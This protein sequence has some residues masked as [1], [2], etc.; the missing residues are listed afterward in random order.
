[1]AT[2]SKGKEKDYVAIARKQITKPS[3]RKRRPKFLVYSR[4]KKGKT[5][6]C[7]SAPN[8]LVIDPEFGTD[9]NRQ[10]DPHVWHVGSWAMMQ[11]VLG[12]AKT[13]E[14]CPKPECQKNPHS[15]DWYAVDGMTKIH[16]LALHHVMKME[17]ERSLERIPGFV[18][19]KDYGKANELVR[20]MMWQFHALP[21]GV[22]YT[23][24][25]RMLVEGE[26][27][28]ED[29]E[30]ENPDVQ[31][32]PDLPKGIRSEGNAIVDVIGRLYIVKAEDRKDPNKTVLERRLWISPSDSYDTGYRSDWGP[33]PDYLRRPTV[34]RLVNLIRTGS[35]TGKKK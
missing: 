1:M 22:I 13:G 2:K 4:N 28:D 21:Q 29:E 19:Q 15:I 7:L 16:K 34:P 9:E 14:P 33:L 32:V 10:D 11:N 8:V 26:F 24:Q 18:Q 23:T 3:E 27:A 31:Y 25:E 12:F 20:D 30:V 5:K 6:F 17:E 35:P